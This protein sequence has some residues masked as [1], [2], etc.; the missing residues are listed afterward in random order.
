LTKA[1][2]KAPVPLHSRIFPKLLRR[3]TRDKFVWQRSFHHGCKLACHESFHQKN[4]HPSARRLSNE[5]LVCHTSWCFGRNHIMMSHPTFVWHTNVRGER[6]QERSSIK[7]WANGFSSTGKRSIASSSRCYPI[8]NPLSPARR[9]LIRINLS[10]KISSNSKSGM[11]HSRE[12][13]CPAL[14]PTSWSNAL[15]QVQQ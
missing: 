14:A 13:L 10:I 8:R 4:P 3:A 5:Q 15:P 7:N 2:V 9:A 6:R 11:K 1:K 12:Q